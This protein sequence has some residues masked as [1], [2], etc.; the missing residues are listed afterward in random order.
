M[1]VL[2]AGTAC[3]IIASACAS[4]PGAPL[5]QPCAVGEDVLVSNQS[6]E[7][8][9]VYAAERTANFM[10]TDD[11]YYQ[12]RGPGY[13]ELGLLDPGEERAF[14]VDSKIR[15]AV[16]PVFNPIETNGRLR[17]P[18]DVFFACVPPVD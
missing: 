9:R 18:K 7:L 10:I 17:M 1:R 12:G 15:V 2:I 8:I 11:G 13:N 5:K 14:A 3:G 16:M 6:T 4:L